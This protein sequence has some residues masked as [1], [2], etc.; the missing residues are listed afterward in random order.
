MYRA[1]TATAV[2]PACDVYFQRG[3]G[4]STAAFRDRDGLNYIMT[5]DVDEDYLG[6]LIEA[7]LAERQ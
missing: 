1:S 6:N 4:A 2:G 5:S 7:A 3:G